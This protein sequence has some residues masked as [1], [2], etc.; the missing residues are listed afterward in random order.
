MS[1][2]FKSLTAAAALIGGMVVSGANA[3][4]VII[5]DFT[6][7]IFE[8][9]TGLFLNGTGNVAGQ[10][11][12]SMI[13][14]ERD[15]YLEVTS[16]VAGNPDASAEVQ[17]GTGY[18]EYSNRIGAESNF[19]IQ[20]DGSDAASAG[21]ASMSNPTGQLSF[22]LGGVDLTMGGAFDAFGNLFDL[23][24]NTV[25]SFIMLFTDAGNF[26]VHDFNKQG[27]ETGFQHYAKY[28]NSGAPDA[29]TIGAGTGADFANINAIVIGGRAPSG[30]GT[31]LNLQMQFLNS[32]SVPEPTTVALFGAGLVGM[33]AVRRR[34]K[35]AA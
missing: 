32:I 10:Q 7:G 9:G 1:C 30:S 20:W 11:L 21:G 4:P 14:G 29:F 2:S 25:V 13:G 16:E 6:T 22:G 12:G 8:S 23:D 3:A 33:G 18:F 26:S 28:E 35:A 34:R 27:P 31:G 19:L 17:S 24:G 5:D 15:V